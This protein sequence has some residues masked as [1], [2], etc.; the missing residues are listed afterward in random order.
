MQCIQKLPRYQGQLFDGGTDLT[1]RDVGVAKETDYL[2]VQVNVHPDLGTQCQGAKFF[3]LQEIIANPAHGGKI[4]HS[5]LANHADMAYVLPVLADED[6][7]T[8]KSLGGL[9]LELVAAVE[10]LTSFL[11]NLLTDIEERILMATGLRGRLSAA[12]RLKSEIRW[13]SASSDSFR[14]MVRT[15]RVSSFVSNSA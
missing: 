3:R 8:V 1:P 13:R 9:E 5:E 12:P 6:Q 10:Y 14:C 11:R 7:K 4:A 2:S 15:T